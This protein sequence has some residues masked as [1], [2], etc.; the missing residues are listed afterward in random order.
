MENKYV[1]FEVYRP[2]KSPTEKGEYMGKTPNLEQARRAADAVGG[3]LYGITSDGR[4]VLWTLSL[5]SCVRLSKPETSALRS[6]IKEKIM[7]F[8]ICMPTGKD[9]I[10]DDAVIRNALLTA[11]NRITLMDEKS[12]EF[13]AGDGNQNMVTFEVSE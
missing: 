3:A 12:G 11:V 10:Q 8:L 2:V 4:K 13:E 1:S 7:K 6:S 9:G 5:A